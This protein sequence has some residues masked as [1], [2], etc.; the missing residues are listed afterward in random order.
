MLRNYARY[1]SE[2]QVYF[3]QIVGR[4]RLEELA[5]DNSILA[6]GPDGQNW[7]VWAKSEL[8]GMFRERCNE[9]DLESAVAQ[10]DRIEDQ[11]KW[12][13]D[14][15][16]SQFRAL[17]EELT[18]RVKD[19]LQAKLFCYIPKAK[20]RYWENETL[21]GEEVFNK[22][23]EA[24]DDI[25]EAG[26]CFAVGRA[27]G[28]VY[29]CIGIMQAALFKIGDQL[30]CV[31]NLE[32]DDWGSVATKIEAARGMYRTE[33]EKRSK[34]DAEFYARWR[35]RDASYAEL[36]ID[37]NAVKTAWRHSHA[38]FRQNFKM[39]QAEKVL[40]KVKDFVTHAA[41]LLP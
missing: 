16:R 8:W 41:T 11:L 2:L 30:G 25:Y 24:A 14:M 35:R 28:T 10:I 5:Q 37:I 34:S 6:A 21:F 29:H 20:A 40:S 38:H 36:I 12:R 7:S 9:I 19:D 1:F 22:L 18:N 33:A 32:T 39:G 13:P 26:S 15:P 31:I 4:V 3:T 17:I 23:P 27:G